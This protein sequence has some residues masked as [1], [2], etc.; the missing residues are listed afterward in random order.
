V[1][2]RNEAHD[3]HAAA[4]SAHR[5]DTHA[6]VP[7]RQPGINASTIAKNS[8]ANNETTKKTPAQMMRDWYRIWW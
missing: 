2:A 8:R 3:M 6:Q 1:D 4:S 5:S 7:G